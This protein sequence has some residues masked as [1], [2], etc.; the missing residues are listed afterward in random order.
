MNCIG[1]LLPL[2]AS[3]IQPNMPEHLITESLTNIQNL[4]NNGTS[5]LAEVHING[6]GNFTSPSDR[7]VSQFNRQG[8]RSW[9]V[10]DSH[11]SRLLSGRQITAFTTRTPASTNF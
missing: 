8:V 4:H 9:I 7:H 1:L 6:I 3:Q 10:G 11:S 5:I 2:N